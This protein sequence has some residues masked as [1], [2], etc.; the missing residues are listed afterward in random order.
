[1]IRTNITLLSLTPVLALLSIS[2]NGL[3][4][5]FYVAPTGSATAGCSRAEPCSL[6]FAAASAQAGDVVV[7]MDGTYAEPLNVANSGTATDWITFRADE[8]ATPIIEGPGPGPNDDNQDTGVGSKTA[9]YLRFVG[10]VARG[11][12]MGFGNGWTDGEPGS[13]GHWE[14]ES[15]L[16]YSNTRT[17]FTFFSA[18][19]FHLKNSISAHNGSSI[20][21]S[22]SSG[23]TLYQTTGVN[24]VEGTVSFENTD[25]QKHTDG[26]GFIVDEGAHGALFVNNIAFRNGGSCLRL[27]K[28]HSTR[29]VNN[30][31]YHNA[32]DPQ[33][34]GPPNPSELYFTEDGNGTT[35]E[36]VKFINNVFVATGVGGGE[37]P[38]YNQPPT[39]WS[40]N[41][42]TTGAVAF[43]SD[44]EGVTPNFTLSNAATDLVGKASADADVSQVDIGFDPKCITKRPPTL[45][46]SVASASWWQ[47]DI[48]I[49]YIR[50]IG[51]VK[52]CFNAAPRA[53]SDI[54]AYVAS[55]VTT[56]S[57]GSCVPTADP[58]S[59][60]PVSPSP[61]S[62]DPTTS[63]TVNPDTVG[64]ITVNPSVDPTSAGVTSTVA[65]TNS[66]SVNPGSGVSP[67]P[68]ASSAGPVDPAVQ[69]QPGV[70][71]GTVNPSS[72]PSGQDG[73]PAATTG[74]SQVPSQGVAS[75]EEPSVASA[76]SD[77]GCSC[78]TVGGKTHSVFHPLLL[79]SACGLALAFFRRNAK[80]QTL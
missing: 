36:N 12:N 44:P 71:P 19:Q 9:E 33:A 69:P 35:K 47:Y 41:I 27:T 58:V 29:F 10:I 68:V 57:P 64:P 73:A 38:I 62:P 76:T 3:A 52:G 42:T 78:S 55:A 5:T 30:T 20:L 26:S 66:G 43:F 45:V 4:G 34:D 48:D 32:Q 79:A 15:C 22:W 75:T 11:W 40:N 61:V 25:A 67:T 7:L 37:Q 56:V 1:M 50:S 24:I 77:T 53:S 63:S 59:P 18:E 80:R 21:H 17:G 51:G 16:S 2:T 65:E 31:C 70:N 6:S 13:N 74:V 14:I 23:V 60:D 28:S 46:G 72:A 54:G 39:G 49:D 8:C